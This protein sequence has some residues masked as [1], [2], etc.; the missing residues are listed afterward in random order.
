MPRCA[1]CGYI[2]AGS[3]TPMRCPECG[4]RR[5][6][7]Q[8][9]I[10]NELHREGPR[11]VLPVMVRC[12][13]AA[14]L[15]VLPWLL[16]A[17]LSHT[18][19]DACG[20]SFSP[21]PFWMDVAIGP[22]AFAASILLTRPIGAEGADGFGLAATSRL[23]PWIPLLNVAWIPHSLLMLMAILAS[24]L[25]PNPTMMSPQDGWIVAAGVVAVPAQIAWVLCLFHMGNIADY[26][27]DIFL[28]RMAT[29]WCWLW[30]AFLLVVLPVSVIGAA[31]SQAP[32]A[33]SHAFQG[34]LVM[35]DLGLA[36]GFVMAALLWWS[37]A[38]ALTLAYEELDREDRRARREQARYP[39]P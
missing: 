33:W 8:R 20:L 4:H 36:W 27:R 13:T 31:R 29:I 19:M 22:A 39:T 17:I 1:R 21:S 37:T 23:R 38:H 6:F 34:V 5:A 12:L 26:L 10:E 3:P 14:I 9:W 18:F 2:L 28:R 32:D 16:R 35:T 24:P 15:L 25:P 11:V 7:R 30:G